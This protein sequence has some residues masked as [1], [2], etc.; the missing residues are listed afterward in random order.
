MNKLKKETPTVGAVRVL[1]TKSIKD[2]MTWT[3]QIPLYH[4][5]LE[6]ERDDCV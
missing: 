1:I 3:L 2:E 5:I 6:K 4:F